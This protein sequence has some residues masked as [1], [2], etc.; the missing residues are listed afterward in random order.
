MMRDSAL[1]AAERWTKQ[2]GFDVSD[3]NFGYFQVDC[4]NLPPEGV[5]FNNLS[6]RGNV[7]DILMKLYDTKLH[8]KL[9]NFHFDRDPPSVMKF[10]ATAR[11]T[12]TMIFCTLGL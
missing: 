10:Q 1:E 3:R 9:R 5:R 11:S 7:S 12:N 8:E 6:P 2:D 4:V